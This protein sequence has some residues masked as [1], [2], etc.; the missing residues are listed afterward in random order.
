MD[1]ESL[2]W[3]EKYRPKNLDGLEQDANI[4]NL[5][6]NIIET[7]EM[8]HFL[9]YGQ[10]GVGKTSCILAIG[11][12][13]FKEH[14]SSR[15]IE[16]NA[17]D[18]RGINAVREKIT[19]EAKKYVSEI[20]L[21]DGTRIPPYKIIILDEADSMTEE[22]QDA[23][24]VIIEQYSTVTRFCF[25]CNFIAK[26]TDA[27]K[28]RCSP[29]YFKKLSNECMVNKLDY[30]SKKESME[31]KENILNTIIS[32]SNGDMRKAIMILQNVK[33]LYSYK[34]NMN[35]S[36][37][38]MNL[39]EL[40][41]VSQTGIPSSFN[42]EITEDDIY[43]IAASINVK[44]AHKIIDDVLHCENI[45]A[46]SKLCKTIISMGYPIDNILSQLNCAVMETTKLDD[47]D[48]SRIIKYSGP[49]FLRMK[50]CANEYIQLLDY[51]SCIYG[52]KNEIDYY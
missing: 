52:I 18:D 8:T 27:V 12:E 2:P 32:V 50:E 21:G 26:I 10:S 41:L 1:S 23:L 35:K 22:A 45:I 39:N 49:I 36:L 25:I 31:L 16:F 3:I 9:F 38:E 20:V 13:I 17:S 47:K 44:K 37:S 42:P 46:I 15:V 43:D 11:R 34:K 6:R 24:R 29:V 33:Y 14:F 40:N 5:F 19:N 4:I 51:L 48:K 7:G 28:S 30:I